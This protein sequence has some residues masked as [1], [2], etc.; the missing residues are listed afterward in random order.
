MKRA[1]QE[2]RGEMEEQEAENVNIHPRLS[3]RTYPHAPPNAYSHTHTLPLRVVSIVVSS[4]CGRD[5]GL[6][7]HS[8]DGGFY[9]NGR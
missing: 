1:G 2:L 5:Y 7:C 3:M 6:Y 4:N 9:G 8:M